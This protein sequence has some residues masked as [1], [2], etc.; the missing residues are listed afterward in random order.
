MFGLLVSEIRPEH[1]STT[2]SERVVDLTVTTTTAVCR[3]SGKC[4][5]FRSP[6]TT[7]FR[8]YDYSDLDGRSMGQQGSCTAA[9]YQLLFCRP[10]EASVQIIIQHA[11][12]SPAVTFTFFFLRLD[13][14]NLCL[15]KNGTWGKVK[16]LN[17]TSK[18]LICNKRSILPRSH[19]LL[20]LL[21]LLFCCL[22]FPSY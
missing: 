5:S 14:P 6:T 17:D 9:V 10:L 15:L 16:L 22:P 19:L 3:N 13:R 8:D 7:V 1:G 2:P 11:K 12:S 18:D 21:L 4:R 20:L